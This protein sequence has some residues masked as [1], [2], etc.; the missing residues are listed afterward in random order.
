MHCR[1]HP[2]E[3]KIEIELFTF[4]QLFLNF[5]VFLQHFQLF[6]HL[7]HDVCLDFINIFPQFFFFI[8][9]SII[10]HP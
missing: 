5:S 9:L 7:I 8:F 1:I 2:T 10:V 4:S 6:V 3:T